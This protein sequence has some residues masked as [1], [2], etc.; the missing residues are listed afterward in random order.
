MPT[1]TKIVA[2]VL[3]IRLCIERLSMD[4]DREEGD[5][6]VHLFEELCCRIVLD[7]KLTELVCASQPADLFLPATAPLLP[8]GAYEAFGER[9][10]AYH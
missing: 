2:S 7:K 9:K 6:R 8:F 5:T 1:L 3:F 10:L 4:R